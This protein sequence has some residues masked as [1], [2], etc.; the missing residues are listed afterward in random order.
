MMILMIVILMLS[1]QVIIKKLEELDLDQEKQSIKEI[2]VLGNRLEMDGMTSENKFIMDENG[3]IGLGEMDNVHQVLHLERKD[4]PVFLEINGYS[5]IDQISSGIKLGDVETNQHWQ[6]NHRRKPNQELVFKNPINN[7]PIRINNNAPDSVLIIDQDG[8]IKLNH[9]SLHFYHANHGHRIVN[10]GDTVGKISFDAFDGIQSQPIASIHTKIHG[11]PVSSQLLGGK[12][13]IKTLQYGDKILK[14]KITIDG[15]GSIK[16]IPG[17]HLHPTN[18]LH[19]NTTT[20]HHQNLHTNLIITKNLAEIIQQTNQISPSQAFQ[21][22][23]SLQIPFNISQ[24]NNLIPN[25]TIN[26]NAI[27]YKTFI[28]YLIQAFKHLSSILLQ[29]S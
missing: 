22:I 9:Q 16:I 23:N 11:G 17:F 4:E 28:P 2:R 14:D 8:K 29:S 6:I 24:I 27:I 1:V 15:D 13:T 21:I 3:R 19:I 25:S 18:G 20:T 26:N 7:N 10:L 5:D 12:L